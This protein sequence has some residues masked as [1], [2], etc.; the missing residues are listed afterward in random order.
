MG[1]NN[2]SIKVVSKKGTHLELELTITRAG[3]EE[4]YCARNFA[5]QLIYNINSHKHAQG[6]KTSPL[7]KKVCPENLSDKHW[8]MTNQKKFI[9]EVRIISTKNYP[10]EE[11]TE[12]WADEKFKAFW[13]DKSKLPKAI[14]SIEVTDEKWIEHIRPGQRWEA[15]AYDFFADL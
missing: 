13:S 6:L 15:A 8:L 11:D 2:F 4:F 1:R 12:Q 10:L 14:Y 7:G 5:L 3:Q 9:K